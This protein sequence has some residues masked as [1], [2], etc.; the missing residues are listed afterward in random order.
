MTADSAFRTHARTQAGW[1]DALGSPFTALL[2][3]LIADRLDPAGAM[4]LRLDPLPNNH[5]ADATVLRLTGALH[6]QVRQGRAPMLAALYP[7]APLPDPQALW[8]AL[9][10]VLADPALLPWLDSAPQ[11]NEVARSGVLMPGMMVVAAE[12]GLPLRLFELGASAGLNLRLDHYRYRLGTLETGPADAPL[13]LAPVW[14]GADPPGAT[15]R[16]VAR[17][18]VD[19]NPLDVGSADDARRMLAYVWPDQ[20]ERLARMEAAIAAARADPPPLTRGDAADF[21]EAKVAPEA[22]AAT[23]VFHSI[24]FQYFPKNV[25]ARIAAHMA[26]MGARASAQAPLAWLRFE[27]DAV[28]P[29]A[30]AAG[31]PPTLRLTLWPDGRERLLATVHPHGAMVH[32]H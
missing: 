26:A 15:V 32:W 25:Q 16:V 14:Q 18:G 27:F 30:V 3:R 28:D 9:E 20:R 19:L 8:A 23:V 13:L 2:C 10:P 24:A 31:Q 29:D 17:A 11:T 1:C 5:A 21:V 4:A 7:P 12:T 22:G 6:A